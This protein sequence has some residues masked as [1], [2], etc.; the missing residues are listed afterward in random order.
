[1]PNARRQE[2]WNAILATSAIDGHTWIHIVGTA[3]SGKSVLLQDIVDDAVAGD[4]RLLVYT[5]NPK[6]IGDETIEDARRLEKS[7]YL[8]QRKCQDGLQDRKVF[9][10]IHEWHLLFRLVSDPKRL[11][12][13]ILDIFQNS[14]KWGVVFGV[15]TQTL[16][17]D[18]AYNIRLRETS[19]GMYLKILLGSRALVVARQTW[20]TNDARYLWLLQQERMCVICDSHSIRV[21]IIPEI[22][23]KLNNKHEQNAIQN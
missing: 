4:E 7:I 17:L 18:P 22:Q 16:E 14:R 19:Y 13:S 6:G 5:F 20:K 10:A 15:A 21:A 11:Y 9:I 2:K 23:N 1:M 3:G 12:E 8:L